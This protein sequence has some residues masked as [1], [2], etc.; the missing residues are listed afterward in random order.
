MLALVFASQAAL[1]IP[2]QYKVESLGGNDFRYEYTVT[3]DGSLGAGVALEGFTILFDTDLY[4]EGSLLIVTADPL[5]S[6][7]DEFIL[8]GGLGVDPAYDAFEAA[9]AVGETVSGFKVEFYWL[10]S[11][12]PGSQPYQI[13]DPDTFDVLFTGDTQPEA[14]AV[15]ATGSL[16]LMLGG[17]AGLAASMCRRRP[18]DLVPR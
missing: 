12:T 7:W 17:I 8:A 2:I 1:A 16:V 10:G 15:P 11:G 3:N 4:D 9:I 18:R 5:A 14:T 13:Y 6:D